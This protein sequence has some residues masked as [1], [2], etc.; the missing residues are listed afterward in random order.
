MVADG[1]GEAEGQS[2]QKRAATVSAVTPGITQMTQQHAAA[3][4]GSNAMVEW[5]STGNTRISGSGTRRSMAQ[6]GR[7]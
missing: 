5:R 6:P 7:N 4:S 2:M 3:M 1:K